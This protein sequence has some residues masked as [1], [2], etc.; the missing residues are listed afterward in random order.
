MKNYQKN[1]IYPSV[2]FACMLEQLIAADQ[3][4]SYKWHFNIHIWS[5]NLN[6]GFR[7]TSFNLVASWISSNHNIFPCHTHASYCCIA[8]IVFFLC[9]RWLSPLGRR[10]FG[11]VIDNTDEELYYLRK[12]KASETPLFIP[13]QSHSLAPTLFFCIRTTT[14]QLLHAAVVE[15]LSSA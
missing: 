11:D 4:K 1:P 3:H 5:L 2:P 12:C 13:I 10:C 9:C 8:L 7:P 6:L 14:I 15:P